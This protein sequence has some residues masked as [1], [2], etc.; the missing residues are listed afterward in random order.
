MAGFATNGDMEP[1]GGGHHRAIA[2]GDLAHRI[3]GPDMLPEHRVNL[4]IFQ[5]SIRNHLDRAGIEHILF[6]GLEDELDTAGKLAAQIAEHTRGAE[7][8]GGVHIMAAGMTDAFVFG[9]EGQ[10]G[11]FH[12]R[13][14]IEVRAQGDAFAGSLSLD[15]GDHSVAADSGAGRKSHF[16]ELRG[17]VGGGIHLLMAEL[18]ML[19]EVATVRDNLAEMLLYH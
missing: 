10:S 19:M 14:G 5:H 11:G 13:Q 8:S 2:D 7:Q 3:I 9:R 6:G 4:G 1:V 12:N 17:D 18:G 15:D 16:A